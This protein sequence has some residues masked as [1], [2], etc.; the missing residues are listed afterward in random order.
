M[1][2]RINL[3]LTAVLFCFMSSA[4]Y[5][6]ELKSNVFLLVD[7]SN[8]YFTPERIESR[9]QRNIEQFSSA[10][11]SKRDG[12]KRPTLIQVLPIN[13]LSEVSAP[14]CE[15][16]LLRKRLLGGKKKCGA[17]P[18]AFCSTD[19]SE[20]QEYLDDEC[21]EIVL[22]TPVEYATDI[23]GALALTS[24][25]IDSQE[26]NDS[27]IV[28]FSDMFEYR[29]ENLPLSKI[30]LKG[31]KVLVVCGGGFNEETDVI[32]LCSG[33]EDIWRSKLTELGA[34]SVEYTIETSRWADG[35][36]KGFFR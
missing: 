6:N 2:K 9:I 29:L 7:F 3:F 36:A 17:F 4:S 13:A 26:A 12:P 21:S 24:Q 33:T 22:S 5:A 34:S 20:L 1:Q 10:V 25:L 32:K 27:Y 23:S 14:I 19:L 35:K 28:I 11:S 8:S 15:Y 16:K 31:A 18:D 30:D